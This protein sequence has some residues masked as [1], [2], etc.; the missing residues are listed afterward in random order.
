[1]IWNKYVKQRINSWASFVLSWASVGTQI[2]V[3]LIRYEDVKTDAVKEVKRMLDFL[4][5]PYS[6][7]EL[8]QKLSQDF[9]AF[10]RQHKHDEFDHYTNEQRQLLLSVVQE[11][12]SKIHEIST[13]FPTQ[14][15][16]EYL[17]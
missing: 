6:D 17:N 1:M 16:E 14:E 15:L 12:V 13:T 3:L 10:Q 8:K 2:P 4:G 9:T 5:V 7:E 11:T